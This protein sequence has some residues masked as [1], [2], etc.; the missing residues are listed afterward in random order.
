MRPSGLELRIVSLESGAL[1]ACPFPGRDIYYMLCSVFICALRSLYSALNV[2][3]LQCH[4]ITV[5]IFVI[6]LSKMFV[7]TIHFAIKKSEISMF[8]KQIKTKL[9]KL[10]VLFTSRDERFPFLRNMFTRYSNNC[11]TGS[12]A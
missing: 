1:P 2:I 3:P 8:S 9:L 6:P 4:S 11:K 7:D 10:F 12:D 5:L